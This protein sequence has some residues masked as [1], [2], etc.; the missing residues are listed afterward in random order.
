MRSHSHKPG[1]SCPA[2]MARWEARLGAMQVFCRLAGLSFTS[3]I[4]ARTMADLWR[5]G[6]I[7]AFPQ[8]VRKRLEGADPAAVQELLSLILD[9]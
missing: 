4:A 5:R 2:C 1:C 3:P 9:E 8:R 6:I 7:E